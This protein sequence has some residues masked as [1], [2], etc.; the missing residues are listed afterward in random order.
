MTPQE[1]LGERKK[2]GE[3]VFD[4]VIGNGSSGKVKLAYNENTKEVV[5]RDQL[6]TSAL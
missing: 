6:I 3:W 1:L 2:V 5:I 4:K